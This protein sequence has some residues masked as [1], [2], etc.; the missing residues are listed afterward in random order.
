MTSVLHAQLQAA[1]GDAFVIE[2]ELTRG[3]MSHVFV[4]DEIAL[5]RRIVVKVL[6]PDLAASVNMERFKR[7]VALTAR[8]QHP[9]IVP[10]YSTGMVGELPYYTMPLVVGD[11]LRTRLDRDG[12]LPLN[13]AMSIL[14]D[15][16]LALECAHGQNVV[17][18]DIKPDNILL[19][20]RSA[21]VT[22]FGIAKALTMSARK[23]LTIR[24]PATT[25]T[26][27]PTT[28]G[29]TLGTPAY[30]AP[31]QG[32]ADPAIDHRADLYSL[33]IVAYEML[34][35]RTPFGDRPALALIA[36]HVAENPKPISEWRPGLPHALSDLVM[37]LLA[38]EPSERPQT[39]A[40]VL[41]VLASIGSTLGDDATLVPVD[42]ESRSVAVLAFRNISGSTD[43]EYL[44]D[45]ITEEILNVLARIPALRV[46][47][48]S[49]SFAF[50][51]MDVDT[52]VI[53]RTLNVTHLL[54]G[55]VRQS[56]TQLRVTAQLSNAVNGFQ[57]WSERFDRK[58]SDVFEIQDEIAER[59]AAS[60]QVTL[61]DATGE[62]LAHPARRASTDVQAYQLYLKGRYFL[63][64]RVDGMRKAVE[65][66][67]RAVD[68]DPDF[69]L[70]HAGMAEGIFL[71]TLY[72]AE[73]THSGAE[74]ARTAAQR[75]LTLDPNLAEALIVLSNVSL[76][77]DWN[78]AETIGLLDRALM[79]KPSD[80]L[81]HSCHAYYLASLG[82]HD[83]A[84]ERATYATELDPLGLFAKSNLAVMLY[85][86]SRFGESV[87]CSDEI[88]EIAPTNSEAYRWRALSQFHLSQWQ[89]AFTSIDS[90]VQLSQRHHWPLA[91]QAAML[92]RA[93]KIEPARAILDELVH[94]SQSEPIPPLALA[95]VHYGL[96]E[97]DAFFGCL[98]K[99]IEAR[100]VWL[101]LMNIDP[102]FAA[103]REHPRFRAAME[104]IVP[105]G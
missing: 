91:N 45:G 49:S 6:D 66:Y 22:D 26:T 70:A 55:S 64:Q 80:P 103:L 61:F 11:S 73:E 102:G 32:V 71:M 4:A 16:A 7:E 37:L 92:A 8:L 54:E 27:T 41:N 56:G 98:E 48:R 12:A 89:E 3:G 58:L 82:R 77:Y 60:L 95:T 74:R 83:E 78:H 99:A 87:R 51:G 24:T 20:G 52:K 94:R 10:I 86:A 90:A 81:A 43:N 28:L 14:R 88:L 5:G 38:K 44:S 25:P 63:N 34:S 9:H 30:M 65:L 96:G 62:R 84:I 75:A 104:R 85:L 36:A 31:E 46:A 100:D 47:A 2:S 35:G 105:R 97:V 18:R 17:H 68:L 1:F 15:V 21:I 33:G 40:D 13:D 29:M 93:R 23:D 57:M 69:A 76:W 59:I 50:K 72:N 42:A 67:Q 39:A 19:A 53:A 79:L 101:V